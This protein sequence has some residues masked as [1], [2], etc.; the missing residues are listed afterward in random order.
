MAAAGVNEG[1]VQTWHIVTGTF[2]Y[3]GNLVT[4]YMKADQLG[5]PIRVA[6]ASGQMATPRRCRFAAA[7]GCLVGFYRITQP[8][9][10][11]GT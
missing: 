6:Q 9:A 10:G 1:A 2:N 5:G 4:G 7:G 11:S 8:D 3:I